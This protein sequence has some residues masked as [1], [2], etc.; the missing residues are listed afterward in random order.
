[1]LFGAHVSI[2]GGLVK[3]L[4]RAE[5]IGAEV[6]QIFVSSP[7]SFKITKYS[8]DDIVTFVKEYKKQGFKGL[9]FH[10]VYLINLASEKEYLVNLSEE[11]IVHYLRIGERLDAVGTIVHLGSVGKNIELL[12]DSV[13][14]N[15]KQG[16]FG[17]RDGKAFRERSF[18]G[19]STTKGRSDRIQKDFNTN[20]ESIRLFSQ[21][22][23]SIKKILDQTPQ[24]QKFI[25]ENNAGGG[26]RIGATLEELIYFHKEINSDRLAFCID[27]QHLFATGVNVADKQEF[28]DWL[29]KFDNNIGID[30]LVCIHANDSKAELGSKHDRH[31]NIG[32]GKIG[33]KGF[34]NILSQPLL[35]NKPFIL[36]V[37][38]Y[39]GKGP[40]KHNLE[41]IKQ[42]GVS[43]LRKK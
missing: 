37:P 28:G 25:I 30:H 10:A 40:D 7:H 35:K 20:D 5:E 8:D 1:M 14:R 17:C 27:T 33:R 13:T 32:V 6:L 22:V 21:V 36:E 9:F 3:A 34:I 29:E 18:S 4:D 24:S 42:L 31:E 16:L 15:D 2:A 11:S 43:G 19:S 12:V 41:R 23:A 38:G 26:G 39:E